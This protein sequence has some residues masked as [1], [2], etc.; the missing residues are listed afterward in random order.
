MASASSNRDRGRPVV[1]TGA[2]GYVASWVVR[3][4]LSR[5]ATVHGTVRDPNHPTKTAHLR[6]LDDELHAL[7]RRHTTARAS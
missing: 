1:V 3:E 7:C 5:G 2:S 6:A 4:L